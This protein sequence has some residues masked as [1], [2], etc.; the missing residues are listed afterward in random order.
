MF[1]KLNQKDEE[2]NKAN[3]IKNMVSSMGLTTARATAHQ[4]TASNSRTPSS[5]SMKTI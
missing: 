5:S 2:E 3:L 1:L 4:L